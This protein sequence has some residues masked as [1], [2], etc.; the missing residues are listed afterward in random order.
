MSTAAPFYRFDAETSQSPYAMFAQLRAED[1]V[2]R[3]PTGAFI[4]TRH[5]DFLTVHR[6]TRF[7]RQGVM[8]ARL[9][10]EPTYVLPMLFCDPP[11]HTRLRGLVNRAFTLRIVEGLRPHIERTTKELLDAVEKKGSF[12]LISD[13]AYRLPI[14]AI[15]MLIG[16]PVAEQE[17][18]HE[19]ALAHADSLVADPTTPVGRATLEK[20]HRLRK[21]W[22]GYFQRLAHERQ[23]DPREDIISGLVQ[24]RDGADKLT[25]YE[26]VAT[27]M[28]LLFAGHTTTTDAIGNGVVALMQ[29]RGEW[30]RLLRE[31]ALIDS[32]VEEILRFDPPVQSDPRMALADAEIGGVP[33]PK[34]SLVLAMN[35]A[36]NR[37]PAVFPDPDRFDV[38][39]ADNRHVAFGF[40]IHFCLGGTLAKHQLRIA[41]EALLRRYPKLRM[42]TD[43]AKPTWRMNKIFRGLTK[44]DLAFE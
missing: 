9:D 17:R 33:I 24:A 21:E 30:D 37:D 43:D 25:E 13:F 34:G 29:N 36:A 10:N 39:R 7:G 38:G 12:E 41:F 15:C 19:L 4:L 31:P 22:A 44:L 2:H 35:G 11:D 6:D 14:M 26:L 32:A 1:P 27:C 42:K 16:M 8:P 20:A 3:A 28:G 40:G 5:A 18:I 23:R